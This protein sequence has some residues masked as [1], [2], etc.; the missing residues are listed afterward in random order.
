MQQHTGQHILSRCFTNLCDAGTVSSRLGASECTIDIDLPKLSSDR[1]ADVEEEANR[2]VRENIAISARNLSSLKAGALPLRKM[3]DRKGKI[4]IVEI[5]DFD[6][7]ACGGTHL[8]RTG[9]T[10]LILLTGA[11]KYKGRI[12]VSFL[13]GG[14]AAARVAAW[15]SGISKI[16]KKLS[17]GLED[18]PANYTKMLSEKK[19]VI[20]SCNQL[21][22]ILVSFQL[23]EIRGDPKNNPALR[24]IE[25]GDVNTLRRIA[26]SALEEGTV[27]I[28][29]VREADPSS[30]VVAAGEGAPTDLLDLL[31]RIC[32]RFGCRGGGNSAIIQGTGLGKSQ[33]SEFVQSTFEALHGE[34]RS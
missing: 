34:P 17:C 4:R 23:A 30:F 12:R 25:W 10:G 2:I 11:E 32:E 33:V 7:A 1:M 24:V 26:S 20:R 3:P 16:T 9:E 22:D 27:S 15:R 5:K 18:I 14:R 28:I 6:W 31:N 21:I 13:A 29:L 8:A 19:S